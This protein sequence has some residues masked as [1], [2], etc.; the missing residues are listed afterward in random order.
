LIACQKTLSSWR[1]AG[2]RPGAGDTLATTVP[3][4]LAVH[5]S[6]HDLTSL[7]AL[8]EYLHARVSLLVPGAIKLAGWPA[9]PY[10]AT[11]VW[12]PSTQH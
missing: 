6:G 5:N 1:V 2:V 10:T 7:S 8:F 3:A 9:L 4:E 11:W 12:D